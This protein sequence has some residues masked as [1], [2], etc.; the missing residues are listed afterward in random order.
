[1]IKRWK[2]LAAV[3]VTALTLTPAVSASASPTGD[4]TTDVVAARTT[5]VRA[6]GINCPPGFGSNEHRWASLGALAQTT[7]TRVI[8][9]NGTAGDQAYIYDKL[10]TNART[11]M[12]CKRPYI[13]GWFRLASLSAYLDHGGH[14]L[15]LTTE[16]TRGRAVKLAPCRDTNQWQL[17]R[18]S[19]EGALK[20]VAGLCMDVVNYGTANGSRIQTYTCHYRTNQIWLHME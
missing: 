16:A 8:T 4:R 2:A 9:A 10:R 7:R 11:Q 12:W 20:S 1:M 19:P 17:W 15:C 13:N 14:S 3:A 18:S 6:L 5:D